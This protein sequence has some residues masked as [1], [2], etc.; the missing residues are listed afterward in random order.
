MSQTSDNNKRIAKNTLILYVRMLFTVG[1]SFYSTRLILANLGVENYGIYN[2][3][4]GFVSMFYMVTS[5]MTQA[6][7]RFLTFDLGRGDIV[8]LQKTFSTS[9]NILL[10]M[11]LLVVLLAETVGLWFINC[12]LNIAD[13]R[14]MAANWIYQFSILSFVLEMISV[15][16]SASVI[17]HEKMGT[18]AFV[19]VAKVLLTLGIAFALTISPID[20]LVFYGLLVFVVELT[21]QIMYWIYCRRNF[22]ECRYSL[23]MEKDIFREMFGF[24][25]WNFLTT[26]ASMLST[27]GVS[28]LLNMQF[29]PVINAARGV[30]SQINGTVGAFH[31]NFTTALNPQITKTYAAEDFEYIKKLVCKGAKFSYLAF[32]FIA[33][34]CMIEVDFFL[35]VWLK[36]VPAYAGVF[37]QLTLLNSLIE[38]LLNSSETLNKAT[39]KIRNYQLIVSAA[40][41]VVLIA[42]FIALKVTANPTFVVAMTNIIYLLVFVPRILANKPY[43]GMNFCYYYKEVLKGIIVMSVISSAL[44]LLPLIFMADGWI[45]LISVG[46]ISSISIITTSAIFVL[47]KGERD[48]VVNFIKNK[49]KS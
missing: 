41:F 46:L 12:K 28:I 22:V 7:S 25:G 23:R 47:T 14:M 18:F 49:L 33:L 44:S 26:C 30:A 45:R 5:T 13:E 36:E 31:R 10:L 24:A 6:V 15:P 48:M 19:T 21:I 34:P 43:I 40:Q 1:I 37:V 17:S 9:V 16:Y 11:S 3:I 39:G 4:G 32:F 42:S 38:V 8:K 27:Q 20:K 2:V 29:G 35:S